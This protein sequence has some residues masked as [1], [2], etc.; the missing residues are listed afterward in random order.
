LNRSGKK[1]RGTGTL[2]IAGQF[3]DL[4]ASSAEKP[5]RQR[6]QLARPKPSLPQ[7][8]FFMGFAC[9]QPADRDIIRKVSRKRC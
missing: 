9:Q 3:D 5:N 2:A 4:I 8:E 6:R 7:A 1:T